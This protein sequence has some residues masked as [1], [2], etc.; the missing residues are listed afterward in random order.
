MTD[1][2]PSISETRLVT[3][4]EFQ[5]VLAVRTGRAVIVTKEEYERLKPRARLTPQQLYDA[6][7]RRRLGWRSK[8]LRSRDIALFVLERLDDVYL[9][10]LQRQCVEYFGARRAPSRSSL[11]RF[12]IMARRVAE[13]RQ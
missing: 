13:A 6:M 11:S 12:C 1:R 10:D 9:D 4:E 8:T 7:H 2:P 5:S 3:P